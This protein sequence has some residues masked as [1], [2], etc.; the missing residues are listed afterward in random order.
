MPFKRPII[1]D[2][3]NLQLHIGRATLNAIFSIDKWDEQVLYVCLCVSVYVC[4][5]V[6]VWHKQFRYD[7]WNH[8]QLNRSP[9]TLEMSIEIND[10]KSGFNFTDLTWRHFSARHIHAPQNFT[11]VRCLSFAQMCVCGCCKRCWR[12]HDDWCVRVHR[13]KSERDLKWDIPSHSKCHSIRNSHLALLIFATP[14]LT[15]TNM[16]IHYSHTH[17][18]IRQP[19]RVIF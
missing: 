14:G 19:Q 2:F 11:F 15:L 5:C 16:H 8:M 10:C 12:C 9:N 4:V 3:R 6:C 1:A 7:Q 17:T 18:R 13:H